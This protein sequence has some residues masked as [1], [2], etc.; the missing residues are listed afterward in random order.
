MT[1]NRKTKIP[2]Q[3]ISAVWDQFEF[4]IRVLQ[5][6]SKP[7]DKGKRQHEGLGDKLIDALKFI[8]D[9]LKRYVA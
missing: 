6:L 1:L 7:K 8:N 4:Q 3:T 5:S 9:E 2:P